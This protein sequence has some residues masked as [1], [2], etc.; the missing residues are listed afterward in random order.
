VKILAADSNPRPREKVVARIGDFA[1][2]KGYDLE[3]PAGGL[4]PGSQ[5]TVTL[6]YEGQA[7]TPQDLTRFVHFLD[8]AL[9]MA[10]QVDSQPDD[11][12]NPTWSWVPGEVIVDPVRLTVAADAAPGAYSLRVGLYDPTTGARVPLYDSVGQPLPDNQVILTE[13]RVAE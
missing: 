12:G 7:R 3:L 13:L 5:F 1:M 6:Y 9:G 10:A 2:L 11:G 4:R 8:P